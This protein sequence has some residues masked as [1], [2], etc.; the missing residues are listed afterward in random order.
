MLHD[1][2]TC[3]NRKLTISVRRGRTKKFPIS[4]L[5]LYLLLFCNNGWAQDDTI[6]SPLDLKKLS[7]EDLMNIEVTSVSKRPQKLNEVSSAIQ[8]ITGEDIK[9]AGVKTLPEALKL[10][11]NIQIGQV[12]SSQWAV[13]TRGFNNVLANKLLVLVDGRTVYTPM[14]AGVFWD[15]QNLLL[16]DVDR[17]EVISGP[18]GTLWGANAVNGVINIITKNSAETQGLYVDVTKFI[19]QHPDYAKGPF[20]DTSLSNIL[21]QMASLRYGGKINDRINYRVYGTGYRMF[22]TID[23]SIKGNIEENSSKD[24]WSSAQGGIRFDWNASEKDKAM[25]QANVYYGDPNPNGAKRS[26]YVHGEN[27][28]GRW[29]H[30]F[31]D[32]KGDF[33]LQ[34]YYDHT[35]RDFGSKFTEDSKTY[36]IDWQN[37]FQLGKQQT[38][39]YGVGY[40][41]MD[42]RMQNL[43]TFGFF[44]AN[45]TLNLYNAFVQ[46]EI[47]P[48][49]DKLRITV[50]SKIEHNTYTGFQYQPNL[51][52][53][54]LATKQQT[55][56][57]A[58]SRAVRNPARIDRDFR[59]YSNP[60]FPILVG[61]D[62]FRSETVFAYETGWR[63]N[64]SKKLSLSV[65]GFYNMY[66][67][68]R[69]VEP[70]PAA[71]SGYP[72]AI[73]NG[74]KGETYG[75]E[76]SFNSQLT[77]WWSLRGGYTFLWKHLWMKDGSHDANK[78]SVES[79]DPMNQAL[80]QSTI[81][82]PHGFQFGTVAR[83]TDY[84]PKPLV[85]YYID[86]DAR[87]AWN[88]KKHLEL[89]IV[90]QHL[91][92][93]YHTEFLPSSGHGRQ[94][95]RSVYAR[96]AFSF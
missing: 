15:V 93:D 77:G 8:V 78:A 89:S 21:P 29:N 16:E 2:T 70:G 79:N 39:T 64:V 87:L 56:W 68:L 63:F 67:N 4:W 48:V 37:R 9:R 74:V 57:A 95:Q 50:G 19:T 20:S 45:K 53:T 36:D 47:L 88:Y 31:T 96:V 51:R 94:I 92:Y 33:Q 14:Y 5:V 58:A 60:S 27:A 44:P 91:L 18:G 71:T 22:A 86:L 75:S 81:D 17:I 66:D 10:A 49:K 76:L 90:G 26:V 13:S 35:W 65:S 42:H 80:L 52:L 7:L 28:L 85:P 25:L 82:L 11:A 40:R 41:L 84:L 59:I 30:S 6:V 62:T 72:Y 54:W 43:A 32:G 55:I 83:Y 61:T 1:P 24:E 46:Y 3:K 23:T 69:S 73:A 34:V 12:N 38:L